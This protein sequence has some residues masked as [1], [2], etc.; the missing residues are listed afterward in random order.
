MKKWKAYAKNPKNSYLTLFMH[1]PSIRSLKELLKT[2]NIDY[3][4]FIEFIENKKLLVLLDS[5]DEIYP[6]PTLEKE[7]LIKKIYD[8]IPRSTTVKFVVA[9]RDYYVEKLEE[10]EENEIFSNEPGY[11][12]EKKPISPISR[13]ILGNLHP[14]KNKEMVEDFLDN[15][16][17]F[18][19]KLNIE[20]LKT[21]QDY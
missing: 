12:V 14:E 15:K 1:L 21:P 20:T 18:C 2:M 19:K 5:Y 6:H 7:N 17:K 3:N 13:L 4:T 9:C 10:K 11:N 8:E 16:I